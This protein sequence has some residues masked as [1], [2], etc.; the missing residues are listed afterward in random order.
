MQR[1]INDFK[2]SLN[3]YIVYSNG[4]AEPS[5]ATV[6][7]PFFGTWVESS[8]FNDAYFTFAFA[9]SQEEALEILEINPAPKEGDKP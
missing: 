9:K 6:L 1:G 7:A 8:L 3:A 5:N 2:R 4:K